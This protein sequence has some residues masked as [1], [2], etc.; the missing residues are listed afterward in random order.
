MTSVP[1]SGPNRRGPDRRSAVLAVAVV[2]VIVAIAATLLVYLVFFASE[3][4]TAPTL[5]DALRVL[6]PTAPPE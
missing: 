2:I 3:A 1:S 5:D 4:P 6:Q